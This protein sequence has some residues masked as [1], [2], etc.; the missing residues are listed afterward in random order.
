MNPKKMKDMPNYEDGGQ[1]R[2]T[3]TVGENR[4][5]NVTLE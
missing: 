4:L 3:E 5:I 2:W 1:K